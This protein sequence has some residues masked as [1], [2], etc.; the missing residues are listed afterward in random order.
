MAALHCSAVAGGGGG[1][2]ARC[3]YCRGV[4][5][6]YENSLEHP[7]PEA[8]GFHETLKRGDACDGCNHRRKELDKAIC[9]H[10]GLAS[11]KVYGAVPGKDGKLR[12]TYVES[13][14]FAQRYDPI[15][16]HHHVTV[17]QSRAQLSGGNLRLEPPQI[18]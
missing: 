1:G 9:D 15:T 6:G 16:N 7:F 12:R 13:K 14:G 2:M 4:T 18:P 10:R 11:A 17:P 8:M 5:T 3:I